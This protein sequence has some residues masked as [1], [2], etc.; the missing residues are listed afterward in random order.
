MGEPYPGFAPCSTC[1]QYSHSLSEG[2]IAEAFMHFQSMFSHRGDGIPTQYSFSPE[3]RDAAQVLMAAA[4]GIEAQR[5]ETAGLGSREPGRRRR[6]AQP[7]FG[8]PN[9]NGTNPMTKAQPSLLELAPLMK[10]IDIVLSNIVD[11]LEDE[12][13]R[14]YLGSTN[15]VD[16]LK[17][18]SEEI[19]HTVYRIMEAERA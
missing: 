4:R 14:V 2:Q 18:L 10:R 16:T 11:A 7:L 13:D 15:D 9:S 8:H 1:K 3:T 6:D 5:A 19:E 17:A 12:G